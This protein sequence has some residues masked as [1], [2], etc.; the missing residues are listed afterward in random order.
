MEPGI[1]GTGS[2]P[3]HRKYK[4]S[5]SEAPT[6]SW[7]AL[8]ESNVAL[9][10]HRMTNKDENWSK[11]KGTRRFG[12]ESR[13]GKTGMQGYRNECVILLFEKRKTKLTGSSKRYNY[14]ARI[15]NQRFPSNSPPV[16]VIRYN[17]QGCC[18]SFNPTART[19][20]GYIYDQIC[21]PVSQPEIRLQVPSNP[22][23]RF[24]EEK[25]DW[26]SGV[27]LPRLNY[28]R[29]LLFSISLEC[30]LLQDRRLTQQILGG[31]TFSIQKNMTRVGHI[32]PPSLPTST[33][34]NCSLH[35]QNPPPMN[36]TWCIQS[37][38]MRNR[39]LTLEYTVEALE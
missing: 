7:P 18:K 39:V 20:K 11:A 24:T 17:V 15:R 28:S 2:R 38:S 25:P 9:R 37:G 8:T 5:H 29:E 30:A 21:S 14:D 23:P 12:P 35:C 26:Q 10:H 16:I 33:Y 36:R 32:P 13:C 6:G 19:K 31:S 27:Q 34:L 22:S 4:R 1:D 3:E